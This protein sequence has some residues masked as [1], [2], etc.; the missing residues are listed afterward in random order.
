MFMVNDY[1]SFGVHGG[2][3]SGGF[4][5]R[6]G[7]FLKNL[8][9]LLAKDTGEIA[10]TLLPGYHSLPN[11]HPLLVHFPIAFLFT[12]LVFDIIGSLLRNQECR[13]FAGW[14]LYLGSASAVLTVAAG[15][16]AAATVAHSD[17]V[18]PIMMQHKNYALAITSLAILLSLWR[19]V[20]SARFGVM[21]NILYLTLAAIMCFTLSLGADLGGL[22]VYQ[23]GIG[24][25]AVKQPP[26][27]HNATHG[28]AL[29]HEH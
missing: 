26:H 10:A 7:H 17:A 3:H 23:H 4:A 9:A 11:I 13:R 16:Q 12:F 18:H 2:A 5:D 6:L 22:M 8:E 24:V 27:V 14:L 20:V 1:L 19:F 21:A 25:A 29:P 28:H 15:F